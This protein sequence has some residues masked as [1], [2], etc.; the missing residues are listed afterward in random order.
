MMA[1]SGAGVVSYE[2]TVNKLCLQLNTDSEPV[3][4]WSGGFIIVEIDYSNP[5]VC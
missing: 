5:S 1:L 3:L 2:L 4:Y